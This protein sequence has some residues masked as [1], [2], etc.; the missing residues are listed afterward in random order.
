M[1][2]YKKTLI[3]GLQILLKSAL[4][5]A[6][7]AISETLNSKIFWRRIPPGSPYICHPN[8]FLTPGPHSR[9]AAT[10]TV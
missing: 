4:K 2:H 10:V 6:G 3:C 8:S 1:V 9:S 5:N 7:N